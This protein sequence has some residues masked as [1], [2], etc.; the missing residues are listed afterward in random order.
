MPDNLFLIGGIA[1]FLSSL[2]YVP[3]VIKAWPRG[4]TRD[5]STGMLITLTI[6]LTLWIVYGVFREDWVIVWA[7]AVG[8]SLA[9]VVLLC[10]IRDS[11]FRT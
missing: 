6:G 7:N 10:K 5:L 1:A 8:A 9:G 11:V 2:S 4:A 3:Q